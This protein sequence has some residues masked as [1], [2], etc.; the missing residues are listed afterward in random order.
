M[1]IDITLVDEGMAPPTYA[2]ASD[3][4]ADLCSAIDFTLE[5]FE[6]RVVP[7]GIAIALPAGHAGFVHPRS[8]LSSR[9]GVTVVNAPGTIDSGY[10][11]EVKVPLI[12]LD[13]KVPMRISRGDRIAQLIIQEVRQADF[14]V[15]DSLDDSDRGAGGFGSTGGVV[16]GLGN[17]VE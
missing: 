14:R 15:V 3:A 11:G 9:H 2:H 10:R 7:T 16:T 1:Q 4:G 13:P 17:T 6:R 8:G 5:P 12:N